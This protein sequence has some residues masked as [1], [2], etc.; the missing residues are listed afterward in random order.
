MVSTAYP[1]TISGT[2]YTD[3]QCCPGRYEVWAVPY[4]AAGEDEQADDMVAAV[5]KRKL[6]RDMTM[7]AISAIRQGHD[8]KRMSGEP[9]RVANK[10][11]LKG[12]RI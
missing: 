11:V 1:D 12:A 8:A 3:P 7:A 6:N 4:A 9:A 5:W 2:S 10:F